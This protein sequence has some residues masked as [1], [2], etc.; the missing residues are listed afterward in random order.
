MDAAIVDQPLSGTDLLL[1]RTARRIRQTAV[2]RAWGCSRG[3]I[4]RIEAQR[5]PTR[6]AL[7]KYFAAIERAEA[8]R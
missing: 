8:D 5:R 7:D 3:N 2:A 6:A 1:L 4:A